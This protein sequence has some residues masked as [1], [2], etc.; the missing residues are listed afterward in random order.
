MA[1]L[2]VYLYDEVAG[3]MVIAYFVTT[4]VPVLES[5]PCPLRK[6]IVHIHISLSSAITDLSLRTY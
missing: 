5:L 3:L 6:H 2:Y 4:D 1:T